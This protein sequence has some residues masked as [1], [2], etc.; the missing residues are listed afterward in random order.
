MRKYNFSTEDLDELL[1]AHNE[2]KF[3]LSNAE[4]DVIEKI[5][6]NDT[7]V[8]RFHSV[9]DSRIKEMKNLNKLDEKLEKEFST[10][11]KNTK[12]KSK[13]EIIDSAYELTVK[14]ELKDTLKGMDLFPLEVTTLLKQKD[15]LDEFYH[16]WLNVDTPLGEILEDSISESI[17]MLTRY[18][19]EKPKER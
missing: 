9:I 2:H 13:E 1:K 7:S 4:L 3:I 14:E 19:H 15:T 8:L 17:S 6:N 10:F 12:K 5:K 11:R 18:Y 16:D